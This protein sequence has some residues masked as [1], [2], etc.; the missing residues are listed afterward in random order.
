MVASLVALLLLA[1][2]S[3][4]LPESALS[5]TITA[6]VNARPIGELVAQM[7]AAT[8]S[9]LKVAP[10]LARE[11][12]IARLDKAPAAEAM[13]KLA[14]A[15]VGR[16]Q[17]EG[18]TIWLVP[19][20]V[21]RRKDSAAALAARTQA[22]VNELEPKALNRAEADDPSLQGREE[23]KR[24]SPVLQVARL[25]GAAELAS[26]GDGERRVYTDRPNRLQRPLRGNLA[27]IVQ[28]L[29]RPVSLGDDQVPAPRLTGTVAKVLFTA[30]RTE[31]SR[32]VQLSL[33]IYNPEGATIFTDGDSMM[34]FISSGDDEEK[35]PTTP[36]RP[37]DAKPIEYSDA[38]KQLAA[39]IGEFDMESDLETRVPPALR[40]AL[41][42][43]EKNDPIGLPFAD[44]IRAIGRF[45]NQ[46]VIAVLPD[47]M[48]DQFN[49]L[50]DTVGSALSQLRNNP[51]IVFNE[52]EKW[53]S[54][55]PF[56]IA[57]SRRLDRAALGE[58]VRASNGQ[59]V[60]IDTLAAYAMKMGDYANLRIALVHLVV[61]VPGILPVMMD[62]GQSWDML[63]FFGVS[64]LQSNAGQGQWRIPFL[65]LNV[66]QAALARRIALSTNAEI[67][68]EA[69]A[70]AEPIAAEARSSML[71]MM[72]IELAGPSQ[73][74]TRSDYRT[75]PT[76]VLAELPP[77]AAVEI[78]V[79]SGPGIRLEKGGL[80]A[81]FLGSLTPLDVAF[82]E[83]M[84][85]SAPSGEM[86]AFLP[87]LDKVR[88]GTRVNVTV[89]FRYRP[90]V[91]QR[92]SLNSFTTDPKAAAVAFSALPTGF[93]GEVQRYKTDLKAYMERDGRKI[94]DLFGGEGG[95]PVTP[96]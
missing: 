6:E 49:E 22:L 18:K 12:V 25:I 74:P 65:N 34:L 71:G 91:I 50:P 51:E 9:E 44:M 26:L 20:D 96:P 1:P 10:V 48:G 23:A 64:R 21:A 17:R 59:G 78:V 55:K 19:D 33:R 60:S 24:Q 4:L 8:G 53:V 40:E 77:E 2:P 3:E 67:R 47:S 13:D 87:K 28:E 45:R 61:L 73:P 29:R 39:L 85:E 32:I 52:E 15:V 66:E 70:A 94:T 56:D 27:G 76:E 30:S 16:W 62:E 41:L 80:F 89:T 83:L 38:T 58:L 68:I 11:V 86:M 88:L 37:E 7:A 63:R 69:P 79:S 90:D 31:Q 57:S 72:M 75:E 92:G 5:K 46:Q 84:R 82:L 43:P 36:R 42:N 81:T 95:V 14:W 93:L 54:V 35:E